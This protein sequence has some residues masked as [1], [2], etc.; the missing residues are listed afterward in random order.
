MFIDEESVTEEIGSNKFYFN[1]MSIEKKTI[2]VIFLIS[3]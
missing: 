3:Q 1:S 2:L